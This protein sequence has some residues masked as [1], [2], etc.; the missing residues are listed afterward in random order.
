MTGN[1]ARGCACASSDAEAIAVGL[2][3][4]YVAVRSAQETTQ[5]TAVAPS[6]VAVPG[7]NVTVKQTALV[8]TGS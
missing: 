8:S 5:R 4:V 7:E 2:W 3:V 1:Y 6:V